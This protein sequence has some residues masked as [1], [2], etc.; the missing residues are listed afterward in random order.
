[1]GYTIELS[2]NARKHNNV[3]TLKTRI[4]NMAYEYNCER[5]YT[6]HEID[7]IDNKITNHQSV[8]M[9]TFDYD[10][11]TKFIEFIKLLKKERR[12]GI[13]IESVYEDDCVY[14]ILYASAKY[15]KKIEKKSAIEFKE[16][17]KKRILECSTT[18]KTTPEFLILKEFYK[19]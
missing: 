15:L 16:T 12:N 2:F 19:I 6:M 18:T 11:I 14:K 8:T 9:I 13:Y 3:T 1:M 10:N 5:C 7:G 4:D 17:N